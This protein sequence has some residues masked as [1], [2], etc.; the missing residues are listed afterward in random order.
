MPEG[1]FADRSG[2]IPGSCSARHGVRDD[3]WGGPRGAGDQMPLQQGGP[4]Q[5]RPSQDGPMV[6][7]ASGQ[8]KHADLVNA[9]VPVYLFLGVL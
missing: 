5:G 9:G 8:L 7:H 3:C 6:L 1:C 2:S 4:Q